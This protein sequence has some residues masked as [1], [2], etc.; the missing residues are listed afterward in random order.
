ML[1]KSHLCDHKKL[2]MS[3]K[4]FVTKTTL[5][6]HVLF[7]RKTIQHSFFYKKYFYKN[8]EMQF[9]EKNEE[10]RMTRLRSEILIKI[11]KNIFFIRTIPQE[12]KGVRVQTC[13]KTFLFIKLCAN[14]DILKC[15]K[16]IQ[17]IKKEKNRNLNKTYKP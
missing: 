16:M 4:F 6:L 3:S 17:Y 2:M 11:K 13:F 8:N 10:L 12:L 1:F 15:Y 7:I 5:W 14:L 9:V